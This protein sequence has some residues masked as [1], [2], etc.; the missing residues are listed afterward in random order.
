MGIRGLWQGNPSQ[1]ICHWFTSLRDQRRERAAIKHIE[2]YN[3]WPVSA[4]YP[5]KKKFLSSSS[6]PAHFPC[7]GKEGF[8]Q[9][10]AVLACMCTGHRAQGT[11]MPC[12]AGSQGH[13]LLLQLGS[14]LLTLWMLPSKDWD[15]QESF[16]GFQWALGQFKVSKPDTGMAIKWQF[17]PQAEL[18]LW[19]HGPSCPVCCSS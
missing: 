9:P 17:R 3:L 1:P 19:L 7:P 12:P 15:L 6:V 13:G 14:L 8:A 11:A 10:S 18:L 2:F 4:W 16:H 5:Q